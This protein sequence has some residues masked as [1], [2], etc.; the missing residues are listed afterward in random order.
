MCSSRSF[1]GLISFPR[2]GG[3]SRGR[4][5]IRLFV[6]KGA[7][8]LKR[9]KKLVGR[10]RK[11]RRGKIEMRGKGDHLWVVVKGEKFFSN[12]RQFGQFCLT[13]LLG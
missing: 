2:R 13:L 5:S 8:V 12:F 3:S 1:R 9:K 10:K 4:P 7:N 6:D 11:G